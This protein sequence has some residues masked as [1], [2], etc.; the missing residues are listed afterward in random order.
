VSVLQLGTLTTYVQIKDYE[1]RPSFFDEESG[2][3]GGICL[4]KAQEVV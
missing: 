1:W 4:V 3:F 2:Q